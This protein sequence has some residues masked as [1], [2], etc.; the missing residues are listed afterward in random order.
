[1]N[2]QT[3]RALIP[4]IVFALFTTVT[5]LPAYSQTLPP[6]GAVVFFRQVDQSL[7]K[8]DKM[9]GDEGAQFDKEYRSKEAS[10]RLKAAK[11]GMD[12]ISRRYGAKMGQGS[13]DL[14]SRNRRIADLE[15]KVDAFNHQTSAGIA[16]EATAQE[17]K[18]NNEATTPEA[19]FAAEKARRDKASAESANAAASEVASAGGSILFSKSPIDIQKPSNLTQRFTAGDSIYGLIQVNKSWRELYNAKS[20][21][22]V[23]IMIVMKIGS[24]ETLQYITL[25]KPELIDSDY[26]VLDI[27]PDPKKMTAYTNPDIEFGEGKGNRKIG[28]I[29]FT[30]DLAQLP[31]GKHT[32]NLFVRDYGD[33]L[34]AGSFEIEGA[35][36]KA[37]ADLHEK[38]KAASEAGET[39]PAAAMV[40]KGL[41]K[42][43]YALLENAGWNHILRVVIIDKDWWIEG[44]K[45]RYLNVAAAA[46]DS[47]GTCYWCKLQ[48]TEPKL[49]TGW[50]EMEL[51]KSG[52]KRN[53]AE[54]NVNN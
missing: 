27:A 28:P 34:A 29:A 41:E 21:T 22:T 14:I 13:S 8:V 54:K 23:G 40:N 32:V 12:T 6:S 24:N 36:F 1:M 4:L 38:V 7:D 33:T 9:L 37:Y 43:M 48:F 10:A 44:N 5:R 19:F 46:K 51:T 15:K 53:I 49:I 52:V 42:K 11:V 35:D 30:Y 17:Q 2:N 3:T 31:P 45:R 16:A 39:L 47:N 26:V 20:K 18:N 50:G 25:K